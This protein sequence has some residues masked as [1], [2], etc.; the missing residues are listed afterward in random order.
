MVNSRR[1]VAS[2]LALLCFG[3]LFAPAWAQSGEEPCQWK[4]EKSGVWGDKDNWESCDDGIPTEDKD[5]NVGGGTHTPVLDSVGVARNITLQ[6]PLII[7][8]DGRLVADSLT[9]EPGGGGHLSNQG[10]VET[11]VNVLGSL[12][13]GG[14]G[15]FERDF[16]VAPLSTLFVSTGGGGG[17]T[18]FNLE[19]D[20][21]NMGTVDTEGNN[22]INFRGQR[23]TN[24]GSITAIV[25]FPDLPHTQ[26][27]AGSGTWDAPGQ[28]FMGGA[29]NVVLANPI[30]VNGGQVR[31]TN[32]SHLNIGAHT[33][34]FEGAPFFYVDLDGSIAGSGTI[35][36]EGELTFSH[37]G[38]ITPTLLLAEGSATGGGS[39]RFVGEIHIEPEATLRVADRSIVTALNNVINEGTIAGATFAFKGGTLT[40][41]GTVTSNVIFEREEGQQTLQG[42]GVFTDTSQAFINRPTVLR[43]GSDHQMNELA[44]RVGAGF[45]ISSRTLS[46][47]GPNRGSNGPLVVAPGGLITTTN[48]TVVYNGTTPQLVTSYIVSYHNLTTNNAQPTEASQTAHPLV[49]RGTLRVQ[50]GPL[51]INRCD[52]HAVQV[53]EGAM[54]TVNE[55]NQVTVSGN[56]TNNGT[57]AAQDG[58]TVVFDGTEAQRIAGENPTT[59]RHLSIKN[60]AGVELDTDAT[61][62]T[63]LTLDHD[64]RATGEQTLTLH[65]T[66]PTTGNGDVWGKVRRP[67]PF[68]AGTAYSFGNPDVRLTFAQ[69]PTLPT[70]IVVELKKERP[71]RF[72]AGIERTYR[73]TA[74]GGQDFTATLRLHYRDEELAVAAEE[75]L[76]LWKQEL[77]GGAWQL[78]PSGTLNTE[79]NWLELSGVAPEGVWMLARPFFFYTPYTT[80]G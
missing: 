33:L 75:E 27:I 57:V 7:G 34:T 68:T 43:L 38:I 14:G 46:I 66:A 58:T 72:T 44:V 42:Q 74:E 73:I 6:G 67:G 61:V 25:R 56:W 65:T 63:R 12:I 48:S 21:H 23:I 39:G 10:I 4:G 19:A 60:P 11:P 36:S 28:I 76:R 80:R 32:G 64:I 31:V 45:D 5:A 17:G 78:Q 8:D 53:D 51:T 41:D 9:T 59:F 29:A 55:N 69:S 24:D 77:N 70:G 15:T 54:L 30:T 47:Q 50:R 20:L 22:S 35:R 40:N 37:D 71:E 49:V 26:T 16:F 62:A 52:C 2:L 13:V 18:S 3:L 79:A 1:Y